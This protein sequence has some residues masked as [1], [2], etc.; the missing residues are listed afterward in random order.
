[1]ILSSRLAAGPLLACAL[2]GSTVF[3]AESAPPPE[4]LVVRHAPHVHVERDGI[5]AMEFEHAAV[6][7]QWREVPGVSGIALQA[8]RNAGHS[9][10]G[11]ARTFARF[12]IHVS[13]PGRFTW[14]SLGRAGKQDDGHPG[15]EFNVRLDPDLGEPDAAVRPSVGEPPIGSFKNNSPTPEQLADP[16]TQAWLRR[17]PVDAAG[18]RF[19]RLRSGDSEEFRWLS[20]AKSS[21]PVQKKMPVE[22]L[23]FEISQPG[24]H[25][26]EITGSGEYGWVLDKLV[27]IRD[28]RTAPTGPGPAETL[29]KLAP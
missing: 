25:T 21:R 23:A 22:P 11:E 3:S 24:F 9:F 4:R 15:N 26:L 27:L 8:P 17:M 14:Y 19:T 7:N 1:M 16:R 6:L 28:G 29:V 13:R 10:R 2:L 12:V 5:I 18:V 20:W